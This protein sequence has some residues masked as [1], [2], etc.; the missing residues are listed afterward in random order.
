MNGGGSM[1]SVGQTMVPMG[2]LC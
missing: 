2:C 1:Y